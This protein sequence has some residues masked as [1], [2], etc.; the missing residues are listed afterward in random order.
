MTCCFPLLERDEPPVTFALSKQGAQ[1]AQIKRYN[2]LSIT[3]LANPHIFSINTKFKLTQKGHRIGSI[4]LF[5]HHLKLF[6][7]VI[8]NVLFFLD[9]KMIWVGVI[10][11]IFNRL[12][13]LNPW[14]QT[15]PESVFI[16]DSRARC[17]ITMRVRQVPISRLPPENT[18]RIHKIHT[19]YTR[20]I[21]GECILTN[22]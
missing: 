21:I 13:L 3:I 18:Y 9:K 12:Y 8:R 15:Y 1:N 10:R 20:Y 16:L 14:I 11:Q 5:W 17:R 6:T 19:E 4:C 22:F 7:K 2:K